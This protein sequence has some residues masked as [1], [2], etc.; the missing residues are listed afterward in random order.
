[1]RQRE[2]EMGEKLVGGVWEGAGY[3]GFKGRFR[4]KMVYGKHIPI[5]EYCKTPLAPLAMDSF[6]QRYTDILGRP[7]LHGYVFI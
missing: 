1:M 7:R 6:S 4:E 3:G 2:L 5:Y